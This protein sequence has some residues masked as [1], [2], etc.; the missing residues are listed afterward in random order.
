M[1]TLRVAGGQE[2]RFAEFVAKVRA[3]GEQWSGGRADLAESLYEA[4][5]DDPELV[6]F[7]RAGGQ[8]LEIFLDGLS[9]NGAVSSPRDLAAELIEGRQ[10]SREVLD[11][12]A[13][14]YTVV[15]ARSLAEGQSEQLSLELTNRGVLVTRRSGALVL[16]VPGAEAELLEELVGQLAGKAW[17]AM[18]ER[19][20][21]DVGDGYSEARDILRLV[22]AGRRSAGVYTVADVLLEFAVIGNGRIATRLAEIV[23]PLRGHTVLWQ[24]L[25]ALSDADFNRN[26]AA[27]DLFIHRSTLDYRLRRIAK[28]TGYDPCGGRGAQMLGAAL[29]ADAAAVK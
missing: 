15:L 28:M 4:A 22:L 23:R 17:V 5:A 1:R 14:A 3:A 24:T 9:R 16:L 25:V 29:I 12:L 10:L 27:K 7:A 8:L 19:A 21:T 2:R 26:Q 13:P 11:R 6:R 20:V 18:A